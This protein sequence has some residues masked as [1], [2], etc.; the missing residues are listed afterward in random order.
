MKNLFITI[1][2]FLSFTLTSFA[3][4][5]PVWIQRYNSQGI[6]DDESKDMT[7]DSLGNI[8]ITGYSGGVT[9]AKY[10]NNGQLI[11][12]NYIDYLYFHPSHVKVGKTG[13]TY[14]TAYL[15]WI[16]DWI[17]IKYNNNGD[18]LWTRDYSQGYS[19]GRDPI[20]I[21]LDENENC[22]LSGSTLENKL[23]LIKY[24]SSGNLKMEKTYEFQN[25]SGGNSMVFDGNKNFYIAGWAFTSNP[26]VSNA[27]IVKIDTSGNL[28]WSNI[29]NPNTYITLNAIK[30]VCDKQNNVEVGVRI[31][32]SITRREH[33]CVLKYSSNGDLIWS[34]LFL[35]PIYDDELQTLSSDSKCNVIVGSVSGIPGTAPDYCTIKYDSSGN[36]KWTRFYSGYPNPFLTDDYIRAMLVDSSDNIYVTGNPATI[37][38]DINGNQLWF[39][40]NTFN[41]NFVDCN[42]I[43][44]DKYNNIYLFGNWTSNLS[45]YSFDLFTLKLSQSG[46][47]NPSNN[48]VT[49]SGLYQNFPNPF[50]ASTEIKYQV[51]NDN[52]YVVLKIY[53]ILGQEISTLLSG[54]RDA[55]IYSS[56]FNGSYL[57]SGIYF[58]RLIINNKTIDTKKM[59][60]IK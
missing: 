27:L 55:G 23:G 8:Y 46:S 29:Y 11:W 5:S 40:N 56:I 41:G 60:L 34:K 6:I 44:N 58:Y 17:L 33:F 15:D 18:S 49:I 39:F 13:N 42:V 53:N 20:S 16:G 38:Y 19:D 37:K 3:Q 45:H 28:K 7:M 24:D 57:A 36:K 31:E 21:F 43:L 14:V 50:N 30:I 47:N 22:F 48:T 25:A 54:K 9:T 1:I 35:I 59:F 2:A 10:D 4:V 32:D 12:H 52:S 51:K 26:F